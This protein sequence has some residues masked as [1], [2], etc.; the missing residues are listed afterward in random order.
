MKKAFGRSQYYLEMRA[1]KINFLINAKAHNLETL[2][3]Y[4]LLQSEGIN[5]D[6]SESGGVR[7]ETSSIPY[8]SSYLTENT[9]YVHYEDS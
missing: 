1:A 2:F 6:K 3:D 4:L 7:R 5:F 8:D 9:V